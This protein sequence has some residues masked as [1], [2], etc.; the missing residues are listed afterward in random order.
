M[1][2][3]HFLKSNTPLPKVRACV[4][5]FV[6]AYSA[7]YFPSS[8]GEYCLHLLVYVSVALNP[9]NEISTFL[10]N[11][12]KNYPATSE[13]TRNNWFRNNQWTEA[14]NHSFRVLKTIF[15]SDCLIFLMHCVLVIHDWFFIKELNHKSFI[16]FERIRFGWQKM[17]Y[18]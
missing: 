15:L 1:C 12:G 3:A 9:E 18:A 6:R 4:R 7:H 14:S 13:T 8:E 5:V 11:S 16:T 2:I 17:K 10:R